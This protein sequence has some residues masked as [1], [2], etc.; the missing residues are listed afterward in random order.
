MPIKGQTTTL[1]DTYKSVLRSRRRVIVVTILM[2]MILCVSLQRS[3]SI[4]ALENQ[5]GRPTFFYIRDRL[6]LAPKLD[7]R[8]LIYAYDDAAVRE[9]GRP[10]LLSGKQW[11]EI[12]GA[13]TSH[14]PKTVFVDMI[15]GNPR[16]DPNDV[17]AMN[18]AFKSSVPIYT[19]AYVA[20]NPIKR[21]KPLNMTFK[22]FAA[23]PEDLD[24]L[25]KY[26]G[27]NS[28]KTAYG[29]AENL[30]DLHRRVGHINFRVPGFFMPVVPFP[31]DK[32]LKHL[33]LSNSELSNVKTNGTGLFINGS[34]IPLN[35]DGEAV[36]DWSTKSAYSKNTY[37]ILDLVESR[38][39]GQ[40]SNLITKD[41]IVLFLPLMFTGNADFKQTFVGQLVGGFVHATVVN[42]VLS[43]KWIRVVDPAYWGILIAV[44]AGFV[45]SVIRRNYVMIIYTL[46]LN[47]AFFLSCL[48]LFISKGWLVEW[49]NCLLAF[50]LISIPVI[51]FSEITE[52][53][54]SIRVNDAL[55]G[56]LSPKMLEKIN[57]SPEGFSLS[58]VEQV[59]TVM[60]IDFVGFSLVA[61]R[62]PSRVVFE[63]LK[64]H[65]KEL[66]DI[67]H[68][69]H[70]I[71]DKSLGDGLLGVFGYDPVTRDVSNRH[72]ED[73]LLASIEIQ[74]LIATECAAFNNATD[75]GDKVI[76]AS[77][78]GLNTGTVFIGNIGEEGRLDLTVIGHTVNMGKRYEDAC[79]PFKILL[80]PNTE[81]HL[82]G[83]LRRLLTKRDIQIK[84]HAEL[85]Q[86]FEMDP[87]HADPQLYTQA[88]KV[89]RDFSKAS[90]SEDR[91]VINPNQSWILMQGEIVEGQVID[92]SNH[93]V[94]VDLNAFYGNKVALTFDLAIKSTQDGKILGKVSDLHAAVK[95]GR[96]SE[97]GF[98]HGLAFTSESSLKFQNFVKE[99]ASS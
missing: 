21:A 81:S 43:G 24:F 57:K 15:F 62:M 49:L 9:W 8:I 41:S 4:E 69:H 68:K 35:E 87:F 38:R 3:G 95:W 71:V 51:I 6:D 12:M 29:P 10:E 99:F 28:T 44:F 98:R 73:A 52:E 31:P 65:F 39:A 79:E 47:V 45:G 19:S 2:S 89:F 91:L 61:E 74:K 93:G 14:N 64:K 90:R 83:N 1:W 84:H 25:K 42:S 22:D 37:S 23:N 97:Q 56:V 60:F 88:L 58:A 82:S 32:M 48:A 76:F 26:Q 16:K 77:R 11:G 30:K 18:R 13:I 17:A 75:N 67:I 70:G 50:N 20:Q 40:Y 33:A 54:R 55:T 94:C 63:S 96:K 66:G 72:A 7:P 5:I 53:I 34:K 85:I 78:V 86:G 80:G 92:Y 46:G 59:V 27:N 36:L